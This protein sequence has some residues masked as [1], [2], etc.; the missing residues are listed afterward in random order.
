MLEFIILGKKMIYLSIFPLIGLAFDVYDVKKNIIKYL[1]WSFLILLIPLIFSYKF[2]V[3][4]LDIILILLLLSLFY[5]DY[6]GKQLEEKKGKK[7]FLWTLLLFILFGIWWSFSN[8]LATT[9]KEKIYSS[10]SYRVY[11]YSDRG[12]SGETAHNYELCK[13]T[14]IPLY[15]KSIQITKK[16]DSCFVH[17]KNDISFN[18]CDN[19]LIHQSSEKVPKQGKIKKKAKG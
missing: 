9:K 14:L 13:N 1:K 6:S 15:E 5:S 10:D 16:V 4:H 2:R 7:A 8:L 17:F 19:Q 11:D 3:N 18:K 12:F